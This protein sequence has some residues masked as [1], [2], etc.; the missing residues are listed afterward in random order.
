M[1]KD[2]KLGDSIF[3]LNE[4]SVGAGGDNRKRSDVQLIQFFLRHFFI[5]RPGLFAKLPK[6][7]KTA[8]PVVAIDGNFG[9]QTAAGIIEFQKFMRDSAKLPTRVDGIVDVATGFVS[10]ISRTH[11]TIHSFNVF[12]FNENS[13]NNPDILN[14]LE[15]HPDIVA[16]AP[17]LQAELAAAQ[18]GDLF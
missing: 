17:E 16:F 7:R 10:K 5:P 2:D 8:P 15:K 11:Y 1:V 18:V 9:P 6:P 3:I 12:F 14:N 13:A 4:T